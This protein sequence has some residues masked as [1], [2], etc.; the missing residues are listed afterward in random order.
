MAD[1]NLTCGYNENFAILINE[2]SDEQKL[3]Q[4]T[5]TDLVN[6]VNNTT[7]KV[8]RLENKIEY[9]VEEHFQKMGQSLERKIDTIK[10]DNGQVDLNAQKDIFKQGLLYLKVI[11]AAQSKNAGKRIQILL[12]PE[13]DAKLFYKIVFGR[14]FMWLVIIVFLI[15]LYNWA[16]HWSDNN[17]QVKMQQLQT[18]RYTNAWNYLYKQSNKKTR[19]LMDSSWNK[20]AYK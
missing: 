1:K 18:E 20:S 14:W 15:F 4:K 13:K 5:M 10:N 12:F 17:K 2:I 7:Q 9:V 3:Q 16:I 8:E 19:K 11:K 6:V